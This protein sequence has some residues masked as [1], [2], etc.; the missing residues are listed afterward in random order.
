[1]NRNLS[2]KIGNG[3]FALLGD[4]LNA[5]VVDVKKN[6]ISPDL[7]KRRALLKKYSLIL[8]DIKKKLDEDKYKS[9]NKDVSNLSKTYKDLNALITTNEILIKIDEAVDNIFDTNKFIQKSVLNSNGNEEEELLALSSI[10]FMQ[11]LVDS[12]LSTIPEKYYVETK[13]LSRD[14][15]NKDDLD[16]LNTIIN[17][18][19]NTNKEIKSA[20][21]TKSM[22]KINKYINTSDVLKKLDNLG[23]KNSINR[24]FTQNTVSRIASQEIRDN[25]SIE[26]LKDAKKLLEEI[27]K[28][29]LS[30][31][32][33]EAS[34]IAK[35]V[36]KE[37][38]KSPKYNSVLDHKFGGQSLK[39]LI[40]IS[41][42]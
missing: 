9:I 2:K 33:K 20:E 40:A 34:G 7:K 19:I 8:K 23:M 21:L 30:D 14:L 13:E 38:S 3:N 37:V 17:T 32:T 1:M 24:E 6:N 26:I 27:D 22:D 39:R 10:Y 5:V 31:L 35:E 12:I 28:N 41:R 16:E 42:R 36:S 11:S 15:F 4:M 29:E 18:M 25:L